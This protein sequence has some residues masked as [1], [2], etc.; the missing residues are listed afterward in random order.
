[1]KGGKELV[2][3]LLQSERG[4]FVPHHPV[5]V[6]Y[7]WFAWGFSTVLSWSISGVGAIDEGHNSSAT[8]ASHIT[9]A[10]FKLPSIS[11]ITMGANLC[12][13]NDYYFMPTVQAVQGF[14]TRPWVESTESIIFNESMTPVANRRENIDEYEK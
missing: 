13:K 10:V 4:T 11:D 7:N 3:S 12:I 9:I 2:T 5:Q 6:A 8:D 14:C 1:M